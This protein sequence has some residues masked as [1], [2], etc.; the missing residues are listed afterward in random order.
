[1]AIIYGSYKAIEIVNKTQVSTSDGV[2]KSYV[3]VSKEIGEKAYVL[4]KNCV[5][6]LCKVQRLL[7]F[8][9]NI[10]YKTYTF[11]QQSPQKTIEENYGDCDDKSNLLISMLHSLD[12]EAYFILVPKHIFVVVPLDDRRLRA[13]KGLWI[14]EKKH[15]ILETTAKGS[16]VGY[17]LQYKLDKITAVI[18]PFSNTK[19]D[20]ETL[21]YK[22]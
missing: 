10:P 7:D 16:S 12:I 2:Y 13:K 8:T 3:T 9:S 11:Q 5:S 19:I 1:M 18:E 21:N 14:N 4:T 20:I 15:Y 17:P 6:K 22:L